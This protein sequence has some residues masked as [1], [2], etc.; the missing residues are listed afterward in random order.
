MKISRRRRAASEALE[1][2]TLSDLAF[3][4]IIYFIVIAGF[5]V[6]QGFLLGLPAKGSSKLV[7]KDDIVVVRMSSSG[8]LWVNGAATSPDEFER[9]LAATAAARPNLSLLLRV[10]P[11]TPWQKVVDMISLAQRR[12]VENFSFTLDRGGGS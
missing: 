1:S 6:N 2:G 8:S 9:R 10:A 3:L 4:L 11:E 7:Y 5:N 12:K